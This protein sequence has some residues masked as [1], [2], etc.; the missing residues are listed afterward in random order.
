MAPIYVFLC[1]LIS[2]SSRKPPREIRTYSLPK[3]SAIDRPI[4]VFPTP[5][6]PVKQ[7]IGDFMSFRNFKTA[8]CSIILFLTSSRPKWSLSKIFWA[9]FKSKLSLEYSFQGNSKNN[10]K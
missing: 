2:D 7:I 9:R 4:E 1:P 10:S 5:G 3:A 8:K 6:G